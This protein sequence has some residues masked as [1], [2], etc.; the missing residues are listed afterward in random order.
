MTPKRAAD[1]A[2]LRAHLEAHYPG[3]RLPRH[4]H[5]EIAKQLNIPLHLAQE[6]SRLGWYI[7]GPMEPGLTRKGHRSMSRKQLREPQSLAD[8][9]ALA[10]AQ[11]WTVTPSGASTGFRPPDP[12]KPIIWIGP[13]IFTGDN[14]AWQNARSRFIRSG[15][16]FGPEAAVAGELD[17]DGPEETPEPRTV[18][19]TPPPG[20]DNP[21]YPD[22]IDIEAPEVTPQAF[23]LLVCQHEQLTQTF[24]EFRR[25]TAEA[26][27]TLLE[28]L[29]EAT[30]KISPLHEAMERAIMDVRQDVNGAL[31]DLRD[32]VS[33]QDTR[34]DARISALQSAL[35]QTLRERDDA[36]FALE[37]RVEGIDPLAAYRQLLREG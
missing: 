12:S 29:A 11:G 7:M 8:L 6:A 25:E 13:H 37:K 35:D 33:R 19:L 26:Q 10:E 34:Q 9:Q 16:K 36:L 15:L 4:A 28:A 24:L 27:N 14:R 5:H 1:R 21:E 23:A 3:R 20:T 2:R 17:L 18:N 22:R 32:M 31:A 30:G